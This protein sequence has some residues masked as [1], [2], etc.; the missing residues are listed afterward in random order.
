MKHF[1][2]I[3]LRGLLAAISLAA[4][5]NHLSAANAVQLAF[6]SQPASNLVVGATLTNVVVQLETWGGAAVA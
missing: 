3:V 6:T 2:R 1:S 5:V 4:G